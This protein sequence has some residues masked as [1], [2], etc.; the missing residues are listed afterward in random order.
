MDLP[1]FFGGVIGGISSMWGHQD[2]S[3]RSPFV[4]ANGRVNGVDL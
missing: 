2:T 1:V 3:Q 4:E